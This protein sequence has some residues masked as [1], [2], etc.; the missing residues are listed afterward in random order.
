MAKANFHIDDA[1]TTLTISD[2]S[3]ALLDGALATALGS[4]ADASHIAVQL[5]SPETLDAQT[6][7]RLVNL[8]Q[9]SD[10][11][12]LS[13]Q[14]SA[15]YLLNSANH[16][17]EVAATSVTLAGDEIVS[18]ATA[19]HLAE[20]PH[21]DLGGYTLYLA[22]NDFADAATLRTIADFGSS[23][24]PNGHT[25]TITQDVL[26]LTPDEYSAVQADNPVANGHAL[27]AIPVDLSVD[28]TGGN[29]VIDGTGV[30]GATVT[31]YDA[32]GSVVTA[33][34]TIPTF[35]VSV[36]DASANMVLTETVGASAATSES[37]PVVLLEQSALE[38]IV[39]TDG[40]TFAASGAVHVTGSEY[41]DIYN[42][43]AAPAHPANPVLVYDPTQH[44]LSLDV[45]G[46]APVVLVTL[47]TATH[48]TSL[49]ATEILVK[50]QIG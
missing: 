4:F 6:A 38:G 12:D 9:F 37:A 42:L 31:L 39:N 7:H 40:A 50:H 49:D 17:A 25:L 20:V 46:H 44:T 47:G 48:A 16:D 2:S 28:A 23:F 19:V 35:H 36:S 1:N 3:E 8:A 24:D 10:N 30:D 15:S 43:S 34:T 33:L 5:S 29:L 18:A 13:I 45:D 32:D 22:S 26:T 41:L 14:D 27:S 21:F 11:G